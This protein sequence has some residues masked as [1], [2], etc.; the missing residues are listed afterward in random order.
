MQKSYILKEN[1]C[2]LYDYDFSILA[3]KLLNKPK[4]TDFRFAESAESSL[5]SRQFSN[6]SCSLKSASNCPCELRKKILEKL[7]CVITYSTS[8]EKCNT[9]YSLY[10]FGETRTFTDFF[11]FYFAE[12][13]SIFT[14]NEIITLLNRINI[15]LSLT[16]IFEPKQM[17]AKQSHLKWYQSER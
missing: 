9:Y 13:S 14:T 8:I 3:N 12:T 16:S 10:F 7:N 1:S 4:A 6:S 2:L 11:H 5:S 17:N 15:E